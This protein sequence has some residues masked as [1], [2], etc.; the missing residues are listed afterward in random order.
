VNNEEIARVLNDLMNAL[1][2][3][4][5]NGKNFNERYLHHYFSQHLSN[6]CSIVFGEEAGL[7]SEWST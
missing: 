4:P 2:L 7:H 3:L 5:Q 6:N 1:S